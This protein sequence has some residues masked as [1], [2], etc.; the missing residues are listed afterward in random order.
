MDITED[1]IERLVFI[2]YLFQKAEEAKN[3]KRP[4]SSSTVLILHD[5]VEC[6]LQ[7]AYE[8][9]TGKAKPSGHLILD[10][11]TTSINEIMAKENKPII[12]KSFIKK[13]NELRNQL[14]HS[15]IFIDKKNIENL[16][17]ETKFFLTDF[18][19][20]IFNLQ[21]EKISL[22]ELISNQLVKD[23]LNQANGFIN[24]GELQK[25]IFAIGKAFYEL[26]DLSTSIAGKHGENILTKKN[27]V[28]YLNKYRASFGGSI[29]DQTLQ[30]NLAEIAEDINALQ[31]EI[32][33]I[34]KIMSLSVD[35][36][37]YMKFKNI[38]PIVRKII[39]GK[40]IN[41]LK[42]IFWIQE[43]EQNIK[44]EYQLEDVIFSFDFVLDLALKNEN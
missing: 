27:S 39:N 7:L 41:N 3:L 23:Y 9:I 11:Y 22:L 31:D 2:K 30:E 43:E 44:V 38:M 8:Q 28:D 5:C 1:K 15:T 16:Y 36:K 33:D 24:H 13:I 17:F 4:L 25:A 37:S 21:F 42:L 35:L 26:E 6:F 10:T 29:P 12:K 34:R 32:H 40:D 14:K 18:T 19:E 20:I